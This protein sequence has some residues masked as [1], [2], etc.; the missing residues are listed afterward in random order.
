M[1]EVKENTVVAEK[2][3]TETPTATT[4]TPVKKDNSD[5]FAIIAIVL[6]VINLGSWIIP[7]CG[8]I[9]TIAGVVLGIMGLKSEKYKTFVIIALVI[10]GVAFVLSIINSIAGIAMA[11]SY[12]FDNFNY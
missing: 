11:D 5:T 2:V 1:A 4:T 6:G 3:D 7:C 12:N 8:Y 9:F 10:A